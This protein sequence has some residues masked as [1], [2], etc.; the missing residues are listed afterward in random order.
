MIRSLSSVLPRAPLRV[1]P[2]RPPTAPLWAAINID[3]DECRIYDEERDALL[4]V[5]H[6]IIRR[7]RFEAYP[8]PKD[9]KEMTNEALAAVVKKHEGEDKGWVVTQTTKGEP[10]DGEA[11]EPFFQY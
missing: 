11:G 1:L 3:N 7:S 2:P 4:Y 5:A 9:P 10:G 8:F 6:E